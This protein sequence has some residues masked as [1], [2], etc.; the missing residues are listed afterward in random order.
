[1]DKHSRLLQKST[2]YSLKSFIVQAPG[3]IKSYKIGIKNLYALSV[4]PSV[5]HWD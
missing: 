2:N 1:M 4:A 3:L 5:I